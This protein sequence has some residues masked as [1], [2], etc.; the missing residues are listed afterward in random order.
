MFITFKIRG[1]KVWCALKSFSCH[2]VVYI[3][4][5]S[6]FY[7]RIAAPRITFSCLQGAWGH[8]RIKDEEM[9]I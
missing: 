2:I 6:I 8:Q 1:Q 5:I 9:K 7:I 4:L 3:F